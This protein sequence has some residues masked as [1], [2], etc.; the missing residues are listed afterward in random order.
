M[1]YQIVYT[2]EDMLGSLFENKKKD[3]WDLVTMFRP[4]DTY[5]QMFGCVFRNTECTIVK[6]EREA[7][8]GMAEMFFRNTKTNNMNDF[9]PTYNHSREDSA[10]TPCAQCK[11][12][13]DFLKEVEE[14]KQSAWQALGALIGSHAADD[15]VQGEARIRLAKCFGI[16]STLKRE[17]K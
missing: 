14:L 10:L 3:G 13:Q 16:N 11:Q 9:R 5:H 2:I 7:C 8:A 4:I 15:S 17:T 6:E 1:N 12:H